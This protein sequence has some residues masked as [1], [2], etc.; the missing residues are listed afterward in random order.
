MSIGKKDI[1][2]N[3]SSKI[4]T[5]SSLS[6]DILNIFIDLI[7]NNSKDKVV[8]FAKFG[9][10]YRKTTPSRNGRNPKTKEEFLITER[11]KLNFKSS[12]IVKANLN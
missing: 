8:K 3:I 2:R 6:L 9:S 1:S 12:N 7:K 5:S 10:F 11:S 4:K